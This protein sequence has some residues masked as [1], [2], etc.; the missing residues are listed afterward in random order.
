M[1]DDLRWED[2]SPRTRIGRPGLIPLILDQLKARPGEWALLREDLANVSTVASRYKRRWREL[3][4]TVRCEPGTG[5]RHG[6][7]YAR[8]VGPK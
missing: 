1:T 5:R 7:L 8:Y 4:F 2:P 6:K 3:E